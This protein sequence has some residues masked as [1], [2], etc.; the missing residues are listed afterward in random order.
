MRS[1]GTSLITCHTRAGVWV[2]VC[3][4]ACVL[5]CACACATIQVPCT[6]PSYAC[7]HA[8]ATM[9][10][11]AWR[12]RAAVDT[13]AVGTSTIC[14]S[15]TCLGAGIACTTGVKDMGKACTVCIKGG[16][17]ATTFPTV[18]VPLVAPVSCSCARASANVRD[19][20]NREL[21]CACKH[22]LGVEASD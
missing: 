15:L 13:C 3:V 9:E 12:G 6:R 19:A 22:G 8:V 18:D 21:V 10:Q 17:T 14:T 5:V 1:T 16:P 20:C 11:A 2:R 4:Y 7:T